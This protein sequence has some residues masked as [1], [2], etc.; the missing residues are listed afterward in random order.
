MAIVYG[1]LF[2]SVHAWLFDRLY[3]R[4]TRD[5]TVERT[6][7][8]LRVGLYVMF[9]LLLAACNV[10]F[11][12]AKVRAVVEDR[13]SAL[14][15]IHA[16]V[17]FIGRN[18]VA[19]AMLYL[20]DFVLFVLVVAIYAAVAPGARGTGATMWI[21]F[22]IGQAYVL[23]RLWVKL[24]SGRRRRRGSRAG[25]P[26][27]EYVAAPEPTGRNRQ[28]LRPSAG[29]SISHVVSGFSRTVL[30]PTQLS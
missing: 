25:S 20:A 30:E 21:G 5:V 11:D 9:G 2:G 10:V 27:P 19:A 12:Y 18:W 22:A 13:R 8:L 17:S 4:M 7:F 1:L 14:A 15:S 24:V 23:G 26:T 29:Q 16:A 28:A 6:A 3:P